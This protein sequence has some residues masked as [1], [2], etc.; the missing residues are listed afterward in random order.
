VEVKEAIG[1]RRTFRYLLPHKPVERAKLQKMLEAAR[2]ASFWGNVQALRAVVVE[3]A[4]ARKEVLDSLMA[5]VAGFQ[6]EQAPVVIVWYLDFAALDVQSDR[7]RELVA[8]RVLGVDEQKARNAL[9]TFLIPFFEQVMP[10]LK[11]S[12]LTEMDCGQGIAQATLVA[13]DEGLGTACLSTAKEAEIKENLRLPDSAK[14]LVLMCVGY[15][16]E[17]LEAGGQR[18]RLPFEDLF[19]LNEA[20][21]VFPRDEA[22][23]EELKRSKLIQRPA[24]LPWRQQ[25]L[26]YL[27]KG[28]DL[29]DF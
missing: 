8:A 14:V 25:E 16:A 18:P 17:S 2:I 10:M 19:S 6:I 12:G 26:E 29:P 27:Q 9:E 13:I 28:L 7:L 20:G 1:T 21:A 15:P 5:P 24:P 11:Q 22:V 4:T 3:R 23:V